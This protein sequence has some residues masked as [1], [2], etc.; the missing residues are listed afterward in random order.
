MPTA[1]GPA[2]CA[3]RPRPARDELPELVV[4]HVG[5]QVLVARDD[6]LA[7]PLQ[8]VRR[9]ARVDPHVLQRAVEP[10][11]VLAHP[12]ALAV[13]RPGDVEHAVAHQEAAIQGIDLHLAERHEV[14]VEVRHVVGHDSSSPFGPGA[15]AS[16]PMSACDA[17]IVPA[18]CG[19]G[20]R[21]SLLRR[22]ASAADDGPR[23][24]AS[25]CRVGGRARQMTGQSDPSGPDRTGRIAGFVHVPSLRLLPDLCEVTA[26]ASRDPAKAKAF[27]E[28]WGIPRVHDTWEALVGRSRARRRR[29]LPARATSTA[30]WRRPR[31]LPASTSSARSRSRSPIP[32]PETLAEAAD[33][34]R[35]AGSTWSRSR[36]GSPPRCATSGASST[37]A[38][39]ARSGTGACPTS[40][41]ASS[42]PRSRSAGAISGRAAAPA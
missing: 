5:P 20:K 36:S 26:V 19:R 14:P 3:Q 40:T 25:R 23:E 39:S 42:T 13:E 2:L 37:R 33:R 32:R 30:P 15:P 28:Q 9:Q 10:V 24:T 6:L 16:W 31:W 17:A 34:A 27:A 38:T 18:F 22:S 12:E 8:L 35:R 21:A 41:T 1:G 4:A 7:D 11:D 29:G